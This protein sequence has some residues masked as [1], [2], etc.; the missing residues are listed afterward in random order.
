MPVPSTPQKREIKTPDGITLED[1]SVDHPALKELE[2]RRKK[3]MRDQSR[4][5][6][7]IEVD[8]YL[9]L[10][11]DSYAQKQEFVE[12]IKDVDSVYDVYYNGEEFAN[13]FGIPIESTGLPAH[14]ENPMKP[15]ADLVDE[16]VIEEAYSRKLSRSISKK[17]LKRK[18]NDG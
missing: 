16:K 12:Q 5:N 8:H 10:V 14:R 9:V 18:L 6:D 17:R 4:Q 13:K 2:E 3:R 11:F 15:W 1:V 7:K